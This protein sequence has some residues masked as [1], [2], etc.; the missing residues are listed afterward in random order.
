[1][2]RPWVSRR[3]RAVWGWLLPHK[4]TSW[5]LSAFTCRVDRDISG[6]RAAVCCAGCALSC[7]PQLTDCGPH[8]DK[9]STQCSKFS[10]T[11]AGRES[12]SPPP[13]AASNIATATTKRD[14]CF[15]IV[16]PPLSRVAKSAPCTY[17]AQ[18]WKVRAASHVQAHLLKFGK[19]H[20]NQRLAFIGNALNSVAG[21]RETLLP[22]RP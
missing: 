19:E 3:G 18:A 9:S 10:P 20:S 8:F 12:E 22:G 21:F 6:N 16:L 13:Q 15:F 4:S 2:E 17:A 1:M 7:S 11:R 14:T 5:R